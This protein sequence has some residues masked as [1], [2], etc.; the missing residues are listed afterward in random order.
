VNVDLS[1]GN[2][3]IASVSTDTITMDNKDKTIHL[4]DNVASLLA[5]NYFI[6]AIDSEPYGEILRYYIFKPVSA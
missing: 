6:K 1:F 5:G 2:M 3:R 4:N